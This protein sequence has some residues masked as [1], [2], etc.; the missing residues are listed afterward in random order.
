[1]AT[2]LPINDLQ[3]GQPLLHMDKVVTYYGPI[4]MLKELTIQV[5]PGE[6]VTLL[7]ANGAGKTTT[8]KTI[9]GLIKPTSGTISF[10]GKITNGLTTGQIIALGLAPVPEARRIF[11]KMTVKENLL[12]GAYVH[13]GG[14]NAQIQEDMEKIFTLFPR[15]RERARQSGGTL[16][17]GEQQMLALGRALMARPK[18]I[19]M[20]EPSMGLAPILVDKVYEI[21]KEINKQGITMLI[22]EQNATMAL[23][24]AHRGYVLQSGSI[25]ITDSAENLLRSENIRKAYLGGA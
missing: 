2:L 12:I 6:V 3:R 15:L 13:R 5:Y 25:V 9:L 10:A 21:I 17:G 7:G 18:M 20:D 16:S 14:P 4:R 23:S 24:V 11:P 19:I 1:M 8:M 22:V